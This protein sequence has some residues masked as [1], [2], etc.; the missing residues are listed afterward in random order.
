MQKH[1]A[2][3]LIVDDIPE[4]I[5]VLFHFLN[6][7]GFE[8]LVAESGE[9]ALENVQIEHPDLILLDVMMPGLDGFETCRLLKENPETRH[10]PIIFMTALSDT[11]DKIKGFGLGAVDYITKPFRHEEVL[12][13]INTHL[14][15]VNLQKQLQAQKIELEKA[16]QELQQQRDTLEKANQELQRLATLDSLTQVANRRRFDEHFEREWR[17]AIREQ[18]FLSLIF[19]DIDYFKNYNDTYG[20][21]AGDDCLQQVAEALNFVVRRPGDLVSRYGGEEFTVLLP[22]TP[23]S[24]A[25]QVAHTIQKHLELLKIV[26]PNSKV[27]RYVTV[28]IGIAS[29]K[30]TLQH[31][32]K[33]MLCLADGAL[34]E[35]KG[36]GRNRVVLQATPENSLE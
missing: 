32:P 25:V 21:Q 24:G 23:P 9:D 20:H 2:T 16:N 19:C 8:L 22:N 30:P 31:T 15:I 5:G 26:H 18:T 3:L 14:T 36:Q 17:R 29:L 1:K 7:H 13:R 28:S 10:I 6:R 12:A 27:S 35:A 4:N 33:E 11:T 34:Y